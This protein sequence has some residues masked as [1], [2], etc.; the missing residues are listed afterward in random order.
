MSVSTLKS[1][2]YRFMVHPDRNA[3]NWFH[4]LEVAARAPGW[5]D[6]TDMD[7]AEFDVFMADGQLITLAAAEAA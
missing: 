3:A 6:C 2:G 7:D 4:P 5:I 1:Q